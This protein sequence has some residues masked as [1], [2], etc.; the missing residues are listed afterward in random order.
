MK[1]R[2]YTTNVISRSIYTPEM[3]FA[4]LCYTH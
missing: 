4:C 3:V 1:M 2:I